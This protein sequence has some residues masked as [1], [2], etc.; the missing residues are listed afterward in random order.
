MHG[1]VC[2]THM[3]R[4]GGVLWP[5]HQQQSWARLCSSKGVPVP[6]DNGTMAS[7]SLARPSRDRNIQDWDN[8]LS[9]HMCTAWIFAVGTAVIANGVTGAVTDGVTLFFFLKK[10]DDLF[11]SSS[12]KDELMIFLSHRHHSHTSPSSKSLLQ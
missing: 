6:W 7:P 2:E 4:T 10:T 9:F 5:Y 1:R 3:S 11:Y 8:S 12:S